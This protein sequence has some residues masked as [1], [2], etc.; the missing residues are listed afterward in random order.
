[1]CPKPPPRPLPLSARLKRRLQRRAEPYWPQRLPRGSAAVASPRTPL[2][3]RL[4]AVSRVCG[5][6]RSRRA[7]AGRRQSA[8]KEPRT[9]GLDSVRQR[10]GRRRGT[11][12]VPGGVNPYRNPRPASND[13][14]RRRLGTQLAAGLPRKFGDQQ[15]RRRAA[16]DRRDR[17]GKEPRTEGLDTVRQHRGRRGGTSIVPGGVGT[18]RGPRSASNDVAT[19]RLGTSQVRRSNGSRGQRVA[20]LPFVLGDGDAVERPSRPRVCAA[21]QQAE[22]VSR[23]SFNGVAA[24]TE[25]HDGFRRVLP[26]RGTPDGVVRHPPGVRYANERRGGSGGECRLRGGSREASLVRDAAPA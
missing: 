11:S 21:T 6:Q 24:A 3:G 7:A 14:A 18:T 9:K 26:A 20:G 12:R 2:T 8:G 1:V 19:R 25:P 4:A 15:C 16:A 23:A 22:L 5:Q 13:V 10:R 17:A